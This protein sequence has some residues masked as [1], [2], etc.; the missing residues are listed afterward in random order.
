AAIRDEHVVAIHAVRDDAPVPYLV[1][2]YTEGPNLDK[3]IRQRGSLEIKEVLRIGSQVASGLA[4]AHRQGLIHRDVK[5]ANILLENGVQRV[6]LTDFG[7]ARAADDVS[8]TQSGIVAGTPLYMSPEQAASEPIDA[9]ADLFSL[10][11]VLYELCTGRPAFRAPNSVAVM[12]RVCEDTPRPIREVNPD[13]PDWLAA[14]ITK[15]HAKSPAQRYQS[16]AEVADL[17]SRGLAQVQ[18]PGMGPLGPRVQSSGA[19]GPPGKAASP[20]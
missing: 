10:G 11:S 2:E 14:I 12:K 5:P 7:L 6:K 20:A 8:L 18:Q 17:L 15:L 16:A 13:I 19:S 3:L 1:M 4:A 9:R